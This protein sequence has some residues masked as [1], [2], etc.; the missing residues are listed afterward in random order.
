MQGGVRLPALLVMALLVMA[1]TELAGVPALRR[2]HAGTVWS[3]SLNAHPWNFPIGV[4]QRVPPLSSQ[5]DAAGALREFFSSRSRIASVRRQ[6]FGRSAARARG[7]STPRCHVSTQHC[8]ASRPSSSRLRDALLFVVAWRFWHR[9]VEQLVELDVGQR[10]L[11]E[12]LFGEQLE[13]ITL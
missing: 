11:L 9:E 12:Q 7:L 3:S 13:A 5:D 2:R 6:A 10:L 8:P 4:G 1:R